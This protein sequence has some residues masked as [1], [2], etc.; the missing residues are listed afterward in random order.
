MGSTRSPRLSVGLLVT[1]HSRSRAEVEGERAL[2]RASR[3]RVRDCRA[4]CSVV[5]ESGPAEVIDLEA[6]RPSG[7][8][9]TA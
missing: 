7:N 2:R 5:K 6:G 8:L 1:R 3:S 9:R 4:H